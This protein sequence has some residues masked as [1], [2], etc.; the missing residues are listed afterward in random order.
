MELIEKV[1][2]GQWSPL[3]NP[4]DRHTRDAMAAK[5]Y[6][7]THAHVQ[8]LI[9]HVIERK[10][11]PAAAF[12]ADFY[13]WYVTLFSPS[14]RAGILSAADLA[15][16]RNNPIFIRNALHVPPAPDA[17]RDC[18]PAMM[19]L[20][21]EE[22]HPGVRAVLGHFIFVFIHPYMDGNGRLS[23]FIMNFMLTTGG[24]PWTI[25]TVQ[26]RRAY[27]EALEQASTHGNIEPFASLICDLITAQAATPVERITQRPE[28]GNWTAPPA[29]AEPTK[30]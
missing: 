6:A 7:A 13:D 28:S 27:L 24:Y 29:R 18:V 2:N 30:H 8:A 16:F 14:V 11:N 22:A 5:G 4:E 15:G 25:V 12:S 26:S 21:E 23:R 1:R 3:T 20:L 19:E 17:V 10:M 9:G